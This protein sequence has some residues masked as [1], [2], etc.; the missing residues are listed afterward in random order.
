MSIEVLFKINTYPLIYSNFGKSPY[1]ESYWF[2]HPTVK[3]GHFSLLVLFHNLFLIFIQEVSTTIIQEKQAFVKFNYGGLGFH[4]RKKIH[5]HPP[6][7]L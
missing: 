4:N 7:P 6:N 2:L 3:R 1:S 5:C